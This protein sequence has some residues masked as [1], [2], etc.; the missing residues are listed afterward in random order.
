MAIQTQ[1]VRFQRPATWVAAAETMIVT[2]LI[3]AIGLWVHRSDPLFLQ[4]P[5]P[6]LMFAPLLTGARYGFSYGFASA[7]GCV[8]LTAGEWHYLIPDGVVFPYQLSLGFM[9]SGM[10]AGEFTDTWLRRVGSLQVLSD[11]QSTRLNE[12]V[13]S[14]HLLKASHDRLEERLAGQR[15]SLRDA[16]LDLRKKFTGVESGRTE[17]KRLAPR[18]LEFLSVHA[19]IQAASLYEVLSDGRLSRQP[20]SSFGQ[21]DETTYITSE[22]P[23]MHACLENKNLISL[24]S[25]GLNQLELQQRHRLLAVVPLLDVHERLWGVIAVTDMPFVVYHEENLY[26]LAVLGGAIGDLLSEAQ[27]AEGYPVQTTSRG[28]ISRLTRWTE[29]AK[30]YRI[31]SMLVGIELPQNSHRGQDIPVHELIFEQL[32]ALDEGLLL[33]RRDGGECMLILMP[34]TGS[35]GANAQRQRLESIISQHMNTAVSETGLVF[36]QHALSKNDQAMKVYRWMCEVCQV[37]SPD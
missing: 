15:Y 12:F 17:L 4:S 8:L 16:L 31:P 7:L 30:R 19:T 9:L 27:E 13:R 21:T 10:L 3:P 34:H 18:I 25:D 32:R 2:L 22:H 14:Y 11:Y 20:L 1:Q 26:L 5:F 37:E 24:R 29:Y 23:M 36:H 6:W 35:V 28:F 33:R